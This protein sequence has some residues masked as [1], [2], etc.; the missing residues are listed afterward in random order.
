MWYFCDKSSY[1]LEDMDNVMFF[2][3][4]YFLL[5]LGLHDHVA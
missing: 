2:I 3:L 5:S 4:F 1:V